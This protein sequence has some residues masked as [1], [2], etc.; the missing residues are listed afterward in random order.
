MAKAAEINYY[1]R[2]TR[3][4]R[5]VRLSPIDPEWV[6]RWRKLGIDLDNFAEEPLYW[7]DV[8]V[9]RWFKEKGP[10]HFAPLDLWDVGWEQKRQWARAQGY[11]DIPEDPIR[12]P[13]TREQKVYHA[14]LA[15]FQRNPFWRDPLDLIRLTEQ[16]LRKL[17]KGVGL[18][19]EHLER[20]GVL[21]P[22]PH[23]SSKRES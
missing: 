1:Y 5:H 12:D 7:Y 8:E 13:R 15:K 19:R 10:A 22:S 20:L 17:A 23:T 16:G 4:D 6:A 3:D 18:R 14:Y 9:L 2:V 11:E 21:G